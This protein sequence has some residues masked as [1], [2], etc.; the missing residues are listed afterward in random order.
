MCCA[1]YAGQPIVQQE[2]E[3]DVLTAT[4]SVDQNPALTYI[5]A[6]ESVMRLV[7]KKKN[8]YF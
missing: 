2:K 8:P 5:K 3:L 4:E 7:K 1:I 6:G